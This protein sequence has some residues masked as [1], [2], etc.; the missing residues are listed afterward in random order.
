[1]SP[2]DLGVCSGGKMVGLSKWWWDCAGM[3]GGCCAGKKWILLELGFERSEDWMW[4]LKLGRIS[5]N[6]ETW[7][8]SVTNYTLK[9]GPGFVG[10]YLK[11]WS[12]IVF[13]ISKLRVWGMCAAKVVSERVFSQVA[14]RNQ[15]S[16]QR[17]VC[18]CLCSWAGRFFTCARFMRSP[19]MLAPALVSVLTS[20]NLQQES[21]SRLFRNW[22][23]YSFLYWQFFSWKR[24]LRTGFAGN[25]LCSLFANY[26]KSL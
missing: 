13:F 1:M 2:P 26:V 7:G 8:S 25:G 15:F 5:G 14:Q 16:H 6:Y 18:I 19:A 10:L 9:D 22:S 4:D 3:C 21:W 24:I 23:L 17:C 20:N 12:V 11:V